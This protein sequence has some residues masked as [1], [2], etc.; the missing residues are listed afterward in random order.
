MIRSKNAFGAIVGLLIT[1][2][3]ICYLVYT[4]MKTSGEIKEDD[5]AVYNS[6]AKDSGID[7]SSKVSAYQSAKSVLNDINAVSKKRMQ[8]AGQR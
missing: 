7:T 8:D 5:A 6:M 2:C 4:Q 3:I 1:V